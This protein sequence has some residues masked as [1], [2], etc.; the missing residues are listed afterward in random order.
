MISYSARDYTK[1]MFNG[2][3][4]PKNRIVLEVIRQFLK[5][6]PKITYDQLS[7]V[8]PAAHFRQGSKGVFTKYEN[9]LRIQKYDRRRHFLEEDETLETYDGIRIAVSTQ[10]AKNLNFDKFL[11]KAR[12][13][14]YLIT[15]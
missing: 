3:R 11:E 4:Y 1:Y 6:N 10:W 12:T 5:D 13:L 9:A 15:A 14:G 7:D 8:F 2:E